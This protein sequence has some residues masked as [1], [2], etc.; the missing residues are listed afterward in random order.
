MS[1]SLFT[2]PLIPFLFLDIV[3]S[4]GSHLS[5]A[6][7]VNI[8]YYKTSSGKTHSLDGGWQIPRHMNPLDI[9]SI[10]DKKA[11]GAS[12]LVPGLIAGVAEAAAKFGRFPLATLLEPSLYFAQKG[13][14]VPPNLA[15]VI[16]KNYNS[17]TLL[18][19]TEGKKWPPSCW[20]CVAGF[21][22]VFRQDSF[23]SRTG[24]R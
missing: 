11:R 14:N 13:F 2:L 20:A 9:P 8:L 6:G 23:R 7:V 5:F 24:A 19:T 17:G 18:H 21:P 10:H 15:D 22:F 1:S 4:A 12:V 16:Q 3:L